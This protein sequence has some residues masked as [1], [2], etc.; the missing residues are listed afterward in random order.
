LTSVSLDHG[1][2]LGDSLPAIAAE[3]LGLLKQDVPVFS[4]V[5]EELRAQV[6]Q[7]AVRAGSPC[8]FLDEQTRWQKRDRTV[9]LMTRRGVLADVPRLPSPVLTRNMALAWLCMEEL[10]ARGVLR[11]PADPARALRSVFLPGRYHQ[12]LAKPDWIFDTAHNTA[13]LTA[14]LD[15]FL[16]QPCRGRR[17]VLFGCMRDK[18]L[19][20]AVG[21]RLRR[22]DGVVATPIGLPRSRN[23]GELSELLDVWDLPQD[24][25][26]IINESLEAA[27]VNLANRI[28]ADDRVL[29]TGSC[30]LVAETL[31][32]L[33]I[34]DLERTREVR[35]AHELLIP[36]R[37]G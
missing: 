9:E 34:R 10:S 27:L 5:A 21:N 24:G 22:C 20:G 28:T 7:T 31:Y 26:G 37:A 14:C 2:I 32:S 4:A 25:S 17:L 33:G 12:V 6:F 8:Y 19:T 35:P 15:V 11:R 13:A 30:F 23:P 1:R 18:D 3:K 16:D 36:F 29:V